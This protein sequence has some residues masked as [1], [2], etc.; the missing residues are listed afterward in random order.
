VGNF[1]HQNRQEADLLPSVTKPPPLPP[2][3]LPPLQLTSSWALCAN[4]FLFLLLACNRT[5]PLLPPP[6][7]TL[8][9]THQPSSL[10]HLHPAKK[11]EQVIH[12]FTNKAKCCLLANLN[13]FALLKAMY[14]SVFYLLL[15][16]IFN[17][18]CIMFMFTVLCR[19]WKA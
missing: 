7:P 3:P 4:P 13:P 1:S 2:S 16:L 14:I 15:L 17:Y 6:L 8:I 10:L 18:F 19:F 5:L 9:P 11:T 12:R